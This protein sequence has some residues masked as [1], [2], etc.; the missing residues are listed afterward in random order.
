MAT[1]PKIDMTPS[2]TCIIFQPPPIPLKILSPPI[3]LPV[4]FLLIRRPWCLRKKQNNTC[5]VTSI[6]GIYLLAFQFDLHA[7]V[8]TP[9]ACIILYIPV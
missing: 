8:V 6:Y 2:S 3:Y 7:L 1:I 9:L 4:S 5:M